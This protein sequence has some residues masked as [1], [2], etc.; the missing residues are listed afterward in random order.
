M[1]RGLVLSLL[2]LGCNSLTSG[3]EDSDAQDQAGVTLTL[4]PPA[5]DVAVDEGGAP[6]R[7]LARTLTAL[8]V[9]AV[10]GRDEAFGRLAQARERFDQSL[11]AL[12][13][14]DATT[15]AVPPEAPKKEPIIARS[16]PA[17]NTFCAERIR[18]TVGFNRSSSSRISVKRATKAVSIALT[19][20]RASKTVAIPSRMEIEIIRKH[21][22]R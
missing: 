17:Q 13:S 4:D 7:L 19:G 1:R 20:G 18:T 12:R 10:Q 14:G 9:E 5:L 8:A 22:F 16:A 15:A 21:S 3:G 2:L 11:A 6:E